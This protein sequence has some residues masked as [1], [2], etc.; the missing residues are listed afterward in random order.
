MKFNFYDNLKNHFGKVRWCL[1]ATAATLLI[2][3]VLLMGI[4][5]ISLPYLTD[6]GDDIEE[7]LSAMLDRPVVIREID[8]DWHWLTPRLKLYDV[9]INKKNKKVQLVRFD[10]VNFEFG[11]F[12][13]LVNMTF[14][15]TM[16]S[17][18][19]GSV[20]FKKD[21]K[22]QF[23]LQGDP[24]AIKRPG[25]GKDIADQSDDIAS[26]LQGK[27]VQFLDMKVQWEDKSRFSSN[28]AFK[29][30][31]ALFEIDRSRYKVLIDAETP[32]QIGKKL[33]LKADIKI[34]KGNK[35]HTKLYINADN[36]KLDY[37]AKFS[38]SSPVSINSIVDA[39][40]WMSLNQF[41]LESVTGSVKTTELM[42]AEN[43]KNNAGNWVAE[44]LA[45]RFLLK[46]KADNL[47][48]VLDDLNMRLAGSNW[49]DVY[50]SL[51]YNTINNALGL[52]CD[53][54][55]LEDVTALAVNLPLKPSVKKL[56]RKYNPKGS[57]SKT[58]I[59]ID[60][61]T[62]PNNWLL[63]TRFSDIGITLEQSNIEVNGLAGDLLLEKDKGK[64]SIDSK[65]ALFSSD[66]FNQPLNIDSLAG[67][68]TILRNAE[69]LQLA[70]NN[71]RAKIDGVDLSA[72]INLQ[73]E[74]ETFLDL[75]VY[76]KHA[77]AEWFNQHRSD[78]LFGKGVAGWLSEA[79]VKAELE[80]PAILI[81]G[82]LKDLPFKNNEGVLQ[83]EFE[84]R[85][86]TLNYQ[87]GWPGIKQ[88]DGRF[89]YEDNVI[90]IDKASGKIFNSKLKN[91]VTTI[92]LTKAP[93]VIIEGDV[94]TN[95]QDIS[96]YFNATPLKDKYQSLLSPVTLKGDVFSR[97]VLDIPLQKNQAINISGLAHLKNNELIINQPG[98][99]LSG[100]SGDVAFENNIISSEKLK[101][102]FNN[103][104]VDIKINTDH[105]ASGD[106]TSISA[107][108]NADLE[109]LIPYKV[110]L[111]DLYKHSPDWNLDVRLNH[112]L[113]KDTAYLSVQLDADLTPTEF[114]LPQPFAKNPGT[115]AK[116]NLN[117]S[118]YATH[119][120]MLVNY[121]N[122]L[123]L[124]MVW[125]ENF[126]HSRGDIRINNGDPVVP[127]TGINISAKVNKF[128]YRQWEKVIM[129][130]TGVT[131][132]TDDH[133]PIQKFALTTDQFKY[134]Q[135]ILS[136][137][138]LRGRSVDGYWDL[139]IDATE[140]IGA[141]KVSADLDKDKAVD[142]R[143]KRLDLT[144]FMRVETD[145]PDETVQSISISPDKLP[146]LKI[147]GENFSFKKYK[148]DRIKAETSRSRYGLTVHALDLEGKDLSLKMK[149]NWFINNLNQDHSSFRIEINSKNVGNMLSFYSFTKSL[150][151]GEGSAVIDW[152]WPASPFDFDWKLVSGR[153][154]ANIENG[155]FIDV[156][157]G[158]GRLLGMFSLSSLPKRFLLD[159]SDTFSEGFKFNELKSQG[160]FREGNLYTT[161][162][163]INGTSA[164]IYFNGRIGLADKDYN[165]VMSVIPRISS[166]VSGWIAVLQ[167]AAVG[168]TAYL[169]QKILG[170]DEAAKNQYHITGS[171]EKPIIKKIG[172]ND[173]TPKQNKETVVDDE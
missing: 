163:H 82:L 148:F 131:N 14:E 143:F 48:L 107:T 83:S 91:T 126:D 113:A 9:T 108:F 5:R 32:K 16:I 139:D 129:P 109:T 124:K 51:E 132:R 45:V 31:N 156:E 2:I 171:W 153:M 52:R 134:D 35:T 18:R 162:T 25:A 121:D 39:E 70:A 65:G 29:H 142:I 11:L 133:V 99:R 84:I 41:D 72:R 6:Y 119:T 17:L 114:M 169:G 61:W 110:N 138:K 116:L 86:G 47:I 73:R 67:D 55:S 117:L 21:K 140:F 10:E 46:K 147:N 24:V 81:H 90:V 75:Q 102:N 30:V 161:Q 7:Y 115:G 166:G 42:V 100:I 141:V 118:M 28:Q 92:A 19:G 50:L 69:V 152:Q 127:K 53:Y 154:T 97:L 79:V 38:P 80:K 125:D 62:T 105:I 155:Q 96:R 12:Q 128:D 95:E 120:D 149:G 145:K 20:F 78:Y 98:Y 164:D 77:T 101:A 93:H 130:F 57:L 157:P 94:E 23:Y 150:K 170:V 122:T 167:G 26:L 172:D 104:P 165:Q 4:L 8:A 146:P 68:F 3:F 158:A 54:M 49:E 136:K 85:N 43:K 34:N 74:K 40:V 76:S 64:L 168:L 60:D 123:R 173:K 1:F 63:K 112:Q 87:P 106:Q 151:G 66:Y 58:D 159:F 71:I 144:P 27:K 135:Y 44:D 13:N 37:L 103:N 88:L 160:N 22:G 33:I 111:T 56:I 59:F 137:S 15:P 89:V 36:I